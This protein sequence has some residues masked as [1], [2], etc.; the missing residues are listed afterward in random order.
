MTEAAENKNYIDAHT[1][2][3]LAQILPLLITGSPGRSIEDSYIHHFV[4]P[5]LQLEFSFDPCFKSHW[6][7][8]SDVKIMNQDPTNQASWCTNPA[9]SSWHD[10][11]MLHTTT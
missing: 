1:A 6:T 5:I 2:Q 11:R 8:D 10:K 9:W 4:A 7:N 3:L